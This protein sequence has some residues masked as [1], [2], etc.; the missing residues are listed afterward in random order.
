MNHS[1]AAIQY[2]SEQAMAAAR[3][4]R[5]TRETSQKRKTG[6]M[7]CHHLRMMLSA[8]PTRKITSVRPLT[9]LAVMGEVERIGEPANDQSQYQLVF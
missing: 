1:G 9:P 4:M 7:V 8:E 6:Q 3:K 2:H 5:S